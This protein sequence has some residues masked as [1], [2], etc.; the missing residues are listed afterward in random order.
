MSRKKRQGRSRI[1]WHRAFYAAIQ[2]ELDDYSHALEFSLEFELNTEPLRI[3][4]VIIKKSADAPIKKNIAAI[5][6][7]VNIVEYKSPRSYV[8]I[9]DFYKVYAYACIYSTLSKA[10]KN[11]A[12]M[13]EMTLTF[14][15]S[16]H[17]KELLAHLKEK[18]G[19]SVEKTG[20]GI[21]TVSGDI[22]PIQIID[23]R[24]LAEEENLWLKGLYN[25]LSA[26]EVQRIADEAEKQGKGARMKAYLKAVLSANAE[27][28]QELPMN[29]TLERVIKNAGL[30]AKW[31]AE[32]EARGEAKKAAE[33][34]QNMLKK[35]FT[36]EQAAEL[37]GLDISKVR[38]LPT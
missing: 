24:K 35:G 6:R 13:D 29:E 3:D 16:R 19:Y 26:K 12:D 14:V 9:K 1:R 5:F 36:A 25:R 7:K 22:L 4:V 37:S 21:Y 32:G 10:V 2:T 27:V 17:S 15:S 18:R 8:S 28:L 23:S 20:A 11:K 38:G 34:A 30:A 31:K 33:V